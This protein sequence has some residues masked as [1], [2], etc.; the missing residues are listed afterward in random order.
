MPEFLKV[1]DVQES[2]SGCGDVWDMGS[3]FIVYLLWLVLVS[4]GPVTVAL[5]GEGGWL[6]STLAFGPSLSPWQ[7]RLVLSTPQ[8][9][10]RLL[11][12]DSS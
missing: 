6:L 11:L 5:C 10:G 3:C 9:E 2:T 7:Q 1:P 12:V 8:G 4:G